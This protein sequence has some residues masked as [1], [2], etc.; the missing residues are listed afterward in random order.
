MFPNQN[1]IALEI[2]KKKKLEKTSKYLEIK[3]HTF[4]QSI[5]QRRSGKENRSIANWMDSHVPFHFQ[6]QGDQLSMS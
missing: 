1:G 3:Q 2:K 6:K 4:K 5:G